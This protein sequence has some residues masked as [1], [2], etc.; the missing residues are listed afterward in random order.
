MKKK[1]TNVTKVNKFKL[2]KIK[3]FDYYLVGIIIFL[4]GFGLIM[5]YSASSY[6]SSMRHGSATFFLKRQ[7]RNTIIGLFLMF[8]MSMI[9]YHKII[10]IV[11]PIY[12]LSVSLCIYVFINGKA[13]NHSPRWLSIFG[14]TFQ[15]SELAKVAVILINAYIISIYTYRN[16]HRKKRLKLLLKSLIPSLILFFLVALSN[17]STAIIILLIS[18]S[19]FFI[20][21]PKSSIFLVLLSILIVPGILFTM[22]Y[23]YRSTRLKIWLHPEDFKEGYQTMQ[24][25][26]AIGSGGFI[27][28]GLGT[29]LQ[30]KFVPE[31]QN[32]MIFTLICEELGVI[33]ALLVII[34]FLFLLYRLFIIVRKAEDK[35]GSFIAAGIFIHIALQVILNISV[36]TNSMP[37]TGVTLP[38]ISYG[39]SSIFFLLGELGIAL[40]VSKVSDFN[41]R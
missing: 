32:D 30:K 39:G 34:L 16:R 27:G 29:S 23:S 35:L 37:N 18:I 6:T 26:Y 8:F 1:E 4:L 31:A 9:D 40:N 3:Y 12:L 11:F 28:K 33:G 25:L 22:F 7:I 5:L 15:P 13:F 36:A 38:F 24:G 14:I 19:M 21:Y 20:A 2:K 17:L 10:K 41:D